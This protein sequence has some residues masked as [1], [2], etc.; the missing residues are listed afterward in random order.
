MAT[1]DTYEALVQSGYSLYKDKLYDRAIKDF[2]EAIRYNEKGHH[3][4]SL[5][6]LARV[7][8]G[9]FDDAVL[10]LETAVRLAPDNENYWEFLKTA[11][12]GAIA[13]ASQ[14]AA[15]E[16]ADKLRRRAVEAEERLRGY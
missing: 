4:Y 11:K 16:W 7:G 15:E 10:D 8:K 12:E 13:R 6:G 1:N 5:R 9:N 3:A 2:N 14:E